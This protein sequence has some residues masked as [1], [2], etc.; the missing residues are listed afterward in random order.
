MNKE[1]AEK[2]IDKLLNVQYA[3]IRAD[4]DSNAEHNLRVERERLVRELIATLCAD[5][6]KARTG[7]TTEEAGK[8]IGNYW[9]AVREQLRS[10]LHGNPRYSAC[11]ASSHDALLA[12]LTAAIA[13]EDKPAPKVLSKEDFVGLVKYLSD[14]ANDMGYGA[15][16]LI[17]SHERLRE[18]LALSYE[19][20]AQYDS[21][22][23]ECK[24]AIGEQD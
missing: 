13:P 17:A 21:D 24:Q 1:E 7:L 22:I 11:V 12:A 19:D 2:R 14:L 9:S 4:V 8:L 16:E 18:L 15:H 20:G 23:A 5:P 6:P 10:E 3:F